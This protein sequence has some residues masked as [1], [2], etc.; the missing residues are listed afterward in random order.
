M[1]EFVKAIIIYMA[2]FILKC[3]IEIIMSRRVGT[4]INHLDKKGG[5]NERR[6]VTGYRNR[7]YR[8]GL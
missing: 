4:I 3:E 7:M 5:A 2:C 8:S 1:K 6:D